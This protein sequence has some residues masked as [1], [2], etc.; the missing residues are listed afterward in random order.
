LWHPEEYIEG[1]PRGTEVVNVNH[2]S[3][4][5]DQQYT[6]AMPMDVSSFQKQIDVLLSQL[7]PN[8]VGI[9]DGFDFHEE[10]LGFAIG[11]WDWQ[12]YESKFEATFTSH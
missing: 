11:A 9:V 8:S 5:C 10:I 1:F 4:F 7:R 6:D 2:I 3:I 12:V